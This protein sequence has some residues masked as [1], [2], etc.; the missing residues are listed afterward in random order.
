M[1]FFGSEPVNELVLSARAKGVDPISLLK[2]PASSYTERSGNVVGGTRRQNFRKPNFRGFRPLNYPKAG[3][4]KARNIKDKSS[5]QVS[6]KARGYSKSA[7]NKRRGKSR[8]P[9]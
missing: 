2:R 9:R 4:S 6:Q 8:A 3:K 7:S 5:K 1:K